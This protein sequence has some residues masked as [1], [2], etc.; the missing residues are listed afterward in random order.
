MGA[1]IV[2]NAEPVAGFSIRSM[3]NFT[4]AA[5]NVVPSWNRTPGLQLE[6][7]A[8]AVG[9]DRPARTS[10]GVIANDES[11]ANSGL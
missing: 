7:D 6:R 3:L 1:R 11:R 4:R 2:R 10:P 9:R 5:S 8:R